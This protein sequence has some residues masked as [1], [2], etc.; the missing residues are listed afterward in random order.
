MRKKIIAGNWKMYTDIFESAELVKALVEKIRNLHSHVEVVLCPPFTSLVVVSS[1]LKGTTIKLGA[2]NIH[3][4]DEGAFTGE[5]SPKMVKSIGCQYVILGHSERREYFHETNDIVNRKVKK[6][7]ASGLTPIV[8]VGERLEEREK[9]ITDQ[10]VG[11]QVKGV[12]KDLR[13]SD[14][15]NL[16]IAYEPVWAI[17]T[18][19]TATPEQAE[20]VHQLIRKLVGQL[21]NWTV[22]EKLIVQYG[23]SVKREN[24]ADLLSQPNIDGALVGG[25]SLKADSFASIIR[26]AEATSTG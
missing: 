20:E 1:L 6:A 22:A 4:E 7:L 18:G 21:Y 11:T 5:I 14:I 2:Q 26:A 3:E 17:G 13:G 23:G 9:D 19:R 25:A 15:G 24:A 8:C 10:V 12:L 16:L